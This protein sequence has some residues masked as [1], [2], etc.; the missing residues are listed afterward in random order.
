MPG[1]DKPLQKKKLKLADLIAISAGQVI[2]AGVVTIIGPAIKSTGISAWLAYGVAVVVGFISILP[3]ILL[4]S[5]VVLQGG[6]YSIVM[7]MMGEKLS[8]IYAVAFITQCLSLSLLGTSMGLYFHSI[9]P[10]INGQLV[11]IFFVTIFFVLNLLGVNIMAKVQKALTAILILALLAFSAVGF[12]HL[13]PAIFDFSSPKFF[14]SGF[15]GFAEA[16]SLYA[17]STYGQYM[18]INFSKDAENPKRDIPIAII[19]ST[20]II[21]ILYVSIAIVDCGVL[22]I[23]SVAGQPLTLVAKK[24]FKGIFFPVFIIGGPL[25]ALATTLNS[26]YGSRA[27]PLLR[28]A[29]DGWFPDSLS[30]CNRQNVPYV[31]M[32]FIFILGIIPLVFNLSIKTITSNLVLVGYLLRMVTATAIVKLPRLYSEQWKKSFLHIPDGLF[33]FLMFLTFL[34][35]IYLVFLSLKSLPPLISAINILFLVLCAIY[36]ITR[37]KSGKVH[38]VSSVTFE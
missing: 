14:S 1:S 20:I 9:F 15:G 28:A 2:G 33:Y 12:F 16:V 32:A 30:K 8:G 38:I 35:Q 4:S 3:F 17:Y 26:T 19:V 10:N 5:T 13:G 24:I 34:A 18:V 21:F 7:G 27:N 37:N 22:P 25:M 29:L 6:E 36:A 23:A 31:I 11:G